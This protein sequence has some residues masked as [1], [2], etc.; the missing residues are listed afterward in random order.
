[1]Q[2]VVAPVV[3]GVFCNWAFPRAVARVADLG[4]VVAVVALSMITG[5]IVAASAPQIAAN[6]GKLVVAA[7]VLH[8]LGFALGYARDQSAALSRDRGAHG[9]HRGRHAEWRHGR[10]AR[11]ETFCH[12]PLA[13]VPASPRGGAPGPH[14]RTAPLPRPPPNP[15]ESRDCRGESSGAADCPRPGRVVPPTELALA[16]LLSGYLAALSQPARMAV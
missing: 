4:P 7:F 8:V 10:D 2:A 12:Q 13:A 6:F 16:L 11:A 15:R 3:I 5:G 1:M 9:E 14:P